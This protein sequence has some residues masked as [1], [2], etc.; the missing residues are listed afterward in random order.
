MNR[1]SHW[2]NVYQT[3]EVNQV[4]WYREHLENSLQLI[5]STNIAKDEA[6]IDIGSGSST[7]IDDL[8]N[9]AFTDIS[10]LDI[11]AK[12]LENS[13]LRL[14]KKAEKVKWIETDITQANLPKNYHSV[15]HDRA[16]FHFLTNIEDRRK[17]VE[18]VNKSLKVGGHIIIAAFSLDGPK[19]CSGLEIVQYSP[20][21]INKELGNNFQ[22][23]NSLK[24]THHTPFETTQE[25]IYCLLRK[26]F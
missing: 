6:I 17:Y 25:F 4:S 24:E 16:V 18:L 23:V 5:L 11:S 14:G 2:K 10:V 20:E 3:K 13:K 21:L 7:L 8:L 26:L 19:K 1:K 12:A 15:W 22:L 9:R